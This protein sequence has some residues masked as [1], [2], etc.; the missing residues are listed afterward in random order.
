M[1]ILTFDNIQNTLSFI[2]KDTIFF[3]QVFSL[4]KIQKR[5]KR[6]NIQNL[7]F[8]SKYTTQVTLHVPLI[9]NKVLTEFVKTVHI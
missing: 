9:S 2:E 7:D 3:K 5:T 4:D 8:L 1:S 6:A